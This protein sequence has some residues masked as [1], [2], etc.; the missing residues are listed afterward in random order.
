M[1]GKIPDP[2]FRK[3]ILIPDAG[4]PDIVKVTF[5]LVGQIPDI[6]Q[7]GI[8]YRP[9]VLLRRFAEFPVIGNNL[10]RSESC[11]LH[12]L[13]GIALHTGAQQQTQSQPQQK[14]DRLFGDY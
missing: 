12:F 8:S 10:L 1:I 3:F 4:V 11:C 5:C 2:I 14:C 13:P 6:H 7:S 9:Q